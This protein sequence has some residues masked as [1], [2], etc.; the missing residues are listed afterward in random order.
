[1]NSFRNIAVRMRP[2][3][4]SDEGTG[5]GPVGRSD[6]DPEAGPEG[7]MRSRLGAD[8][9]SGTAEGAVLRLGPHHAL[10]PETTAPRRVAMDAPKTMPRR[11][12][13]DLDARDGMVPDADPAPQPDAP[14]VSR[15]QAAPSRAKTRILGFHAAALDPVDETDGQVV[16]TGPVLPAGFLVVIEGPGQGAFFPV[17]AHV[18]AIGR[19]ADQDIALDF[20]DESISRSG[21]GSVMYDAEQNRFFLGHG[22]KANAIR[23]NG[24]PVLSTEEMTHNDTIRIG[25]TTLRFLALCGADFTWHA[26][27]KGPDHG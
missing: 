15:P 11:N 26:T 25:K 2:K 6:V 21:H 3:P 13:W 5:A 8:T 27:A 14:V 23:R 10:P 16:P 4:V 19:D 18:A 12:I 20:G 22:N 17:T 1:M 7:G 24:T 9:Q